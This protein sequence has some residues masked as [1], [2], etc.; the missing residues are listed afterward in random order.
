MSKF[1]IRYDRK[2]VSAAFFWHEVEEEFRARGIDW[3]FKGYEC[4]NMEEALNAIND[5]RK[6]ELYKHEE[7]NCLTLCTFPTELHTFVKNMFRAHWNTQ[8]LKHIRFG[9]DARLLIPYNFTN[10]CLFFFSTFFLSLVLFAW[11]NPWHKR[12][13]NLGVF[14]LV[15]IFKI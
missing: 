3:C 7:A 12:E 2:F 4:D 10:C 11:N 9:I 8:N 15:I 14:V 5:M 13:G 6:G 1:D